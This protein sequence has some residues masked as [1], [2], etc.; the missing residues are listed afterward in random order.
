MPESQI[1]NILLIDDDEDDFLLTREMLSAAQGRTCCLH[2]AAT[3]EAGHK[4]LEDPDVYDAILIDYDLGPRTGLDL[5][6][7]AAASGCPTPLILY[8]G[9]GSYEI[10]L[11]AMQ[12]GATLYLT[13]NETTPLL[14][15]RS[16]RYAI[17]RKQIERELRA[18]YERYITDLTRSQAILRQSEQRWAITLSSIGDA[19]IS[20]NVEGMVRF[21][22]PVA[23]AL[24]GWTL[25]EARYHLLIQ[26]FS[27]IDEQTRQPMED[28]VTEVLR[29]DRVVTLSN[30]ALLVRRDGL[31]IPIDDSAA[32]IRGE[33]GQLEGVV[34]IFRDIRERKRSQEAI[35]QSED[36]YYRLFTQARQAEQLS[37]ALNDINQIIHS[38]LDFDQ[39]MERAVSA[40]AQALGSETS[41]LSLREAERWIVRYVY[42]FSQDVVGLQMN[43]DEE[44]HAVLAIQ[45]KQPVAINDAFSDERVNRDHMRQWGVRSVLVAPVLRRSQVVGVIFFNYHQAPMVFLDHHIDFAAKLSASISLALENA[46]LF[47]DLEREIVERRQTE[48][49]L[50]TYAERLRRSNQDLEQFAFVA[51]HDLQEPLRKIQSF[52]ALL[53][54]RAGP[55]LSAEQ[56]GYLNRMQGAVQRMQKMIE[57]LLALSRV[58]TR[59][60]PF[61]TVDLNQVAAEVLEDLEPRLRQTGGAVDLGRLPTLEADPLQMR[62]LL[63]NLLGNALKF[64]QP[65]QP[66]R[67]RVYASAGPQ[68]DE[69]R[70]TVEDQG[71]GFDMEHIGRIFQ[72]FQ[73][74]HGKAEYDGTGMG[75]SICRKIVERHGGRIEVRSQPGE[76][77]A[78]EIILPIPPPADRPR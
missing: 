3:Y 78:F 13:K 10:D 71:I 38:T 7:Q 44:R 32:P 43:D 34:L 51:S 20:T 59:G 52:G 73:R 19:V 28:P 14:L 74:L 9:R 67:V 46:R 17:E 60:Q 63:Q 40:A 36:K 77:A 30:H 45:S 15:E 39:V 68:S 16:I 35:Q 4:A 8:T 66:P 61:V 22:N 25:A 18:S 55:G 2:W 26:I 64:H 57:D 21:M 27:T 69:V 48:A 49:I 37:Q 1:W 54:E 12:A 5:I 42:G 29:E 24:T 41:A 75:L 72:P 56:R 33:D 58:S 62:Q 50:R 6:R 70:I 31:E 23:E 65:N 76:G 53:V 11:E 47:D